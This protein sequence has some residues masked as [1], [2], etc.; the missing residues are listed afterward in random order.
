MC[1]IVAVFSDGA[2]TTARRLVI[3]ESVSVV[4]RIASSTSRRIRDSS[5]GRSGSSP[6]PGGEH[7]I[8]HVAMT[9]VG[10]QATSRDMRMGQQTELLQQGQFVAHGGR[11]AVEVRVGGDRPRRDRLAGSQVVV[12]DLAQDH[13]LSGGE[14]FSQSRS[15]GGTGPPG[16]LERPLDMG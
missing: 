7:A 14:R 12:H 16:S 15:T 3:F 11:P 5:I 1:L 4:A 10:G 13:L 2:E 6:W 8:D 9:G